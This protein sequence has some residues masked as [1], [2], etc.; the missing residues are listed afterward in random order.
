M[1]SFADKLFNVDF[2]TIKP[3]QL[4]DM[5]EVTSLAIY[6]SNSK[7]Y[8]P[9]GLFSETIFGQRDTALR[10]IKPGY[11]DLKM[12]ILH[13]FAYK[14]LIGLDPIFDKVAS[15]KVKAS[16]NNELKTL[17]ED[18]KGETGFEFFMR[19]LPKIEF[20]TRNTKSRSVSI[21]VVK[22]A[23]RPENL[24]R[25]FYVLPAGMRDIEEDSKG[26]PTQD[27]IN[28]I[29]SKMIMAVNGIRNNT[30]RE[31]K[32]AQFD[33]YRY[34]VQL[35]AMDIF[36]YIK[37]LIDGKRGF[38]QSKWASRGIMD[39]T[40][41][42][43]T[44]LPN[45]VSDLKDPNKISFNDT[46]VGLYQFVKSILP[47][48][49]F[50]VNKYFIFG[51]A[52]PASNNVTVIDSK[53]MKTTFKS[54]SSKDKE[55]WTTAQGLNNIFNKLKQDVIKNDY[56]KMANDYIA[57][58]EDKGKEIYVIKD[59]NNIPPGVN[60]SKLRPITYGELIYISVA[61]V[62]KEAKSTVT[63]YPVINLG[64][65]YPSGV[66]LKSTVIGRRVKVYIDNEIMDLP[67]YPVD[68]EKFMGSISASTSH[69]GKLGADYDG[70]SAIGLIH[71][72]FLSSQNSNV[73]KLDINDNISNKENNMPINNSKITY[74][75]GLINL[76][77]F[78]RGNLIKTE[79]NT[80]YYE[81]P[82]NVEVLTVWNGETKWVHPESYS[83]HKNLQMLNVKI[84][85]GGTI[86]C[87]NDHSIVSVDKDLNYVRTNPERGMV[88]PKLRNSY[89][90]Y[91]KP[92]RL[93]YTLQEDNIEFKLNFDMGY[94]FGAII[95]DGWVNFPPEN[96][97]RTDLTAIM[98][99]TVH[100]GI[101]NKIEETLKD[102][103][104]E[105][106]LYSRTEDHE[107]D[108]GIYTHSKHTWNFKP[109][110]SILRKYIGHS[111]LNKQLPSFWC[112][113]A[114]GFRWGL[115]SGLI[116][117]DGTVSISKLGKYSL[118]YST[119]SQ[120]LAYEISGL[121]YSLGLS[122]GIMVATRKTSTVE[123]TVRLLMGGIQNV[124]GKLKLNNKDKAAKLEE[125]CKYYTT[126][127]E[128]EFTPTLSISRLQE[129]R[130]YLNGIKD[131]KASAQVSDVIKRSNSNFGGSF[132]KYIILEI[133]NRYLDFF[134]K[135]DFWKKYESIVLDDTIE[136][137]LIQDVTPLPGIT[138][139]YDI[140]CPPYCTFVMENGVVVYDTVSF[141]AVL[142]KE[143]VK[144]IDNAL[145]SKSYYIMP[146]GSLSYSAAT[147]TLDFVLKHLSAN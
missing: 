81:V 143:A 6:E 130:T 120:K 2:L 145:N 53:T 41:N 84:Y 133:M 64:S 33:P 126:R 125:M 37:N 117:T 32:L 85:K 142:T 51:V 140:T 11:I 118:A 59:T 123:Y 16:F 1:A 136:W 113:T 75:N 147:D 17:V 39:G 86:Q 97:K 7:V 74:T 89:D 10:F 134:T 12:N 40:R 69:L 3:E 106:K 111:A 38:M 28:D 60:V 127:Q 82:E 54:V 44:A 36:F 114:Q 14:I 88:V 47:L 30:I 42:V 103:G 109:V 18:P 139:A 116:D 73:P 25:Y 24:I 115:L 48:A 80:E 131:I 98:L 76:K 61:K 9:K 67:E 20:D 58:V 78:P 104:Y 87:S 49:I 99:A 129:L 91:V 46:T 77:D 66:Y 26:R 57:L 83:I 128:L 121:I 65:I 29:Y 105:G 13:P 100:P 15:G 79:G 122:A 124:I 119:T 137:Q 108:N 146:D 132:Q 72:R 101:K 135:D 95:G 19:T 50:N 45:V 35:I 22:K 52:T 68:G 5:Q 96:G 8:D 107:F 94:L 56:A 62:S 93:K 141:N 31:D 34:R 112:Q 144:E 71:T 110:A 21:E 63:R 90:K 23:I 92:S 102:Y 27:E 70:D 55:A 138:E 4:R 43:L